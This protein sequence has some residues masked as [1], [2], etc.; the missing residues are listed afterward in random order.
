M[1][2]PFF[3]KSH[4][5]WFVEINRKQIN[6]GK[7]RDEAFRQY[8]SMMAGEAPVTGRSTVI[9]LLDQFLI[10]IKENRA[11]RTFDWYY[12]H[13]NPFSKYVGRRTVGELKPIHVTRWLATLPGGTTWKNGAARAVCRAFNWA[14]KQG[15]IRYSPV[16]GLEKPA[17]EHRECYITEDQW[18]AALKILPADDS[19]RDILCFLRET[20]ARPIEARIVTAKHWDR[21][22][23]RIVFETKNSKGKR[24]RRVIRLNQA[25]QEI[26][27]RLAIKTPEG[28]LFRNRRGDPWTMSALNQCCIKLKLDFEFFPY[29][30]RHSWI[31]DALLRGVDPMTVSI[32]AGHRDA[33]MVMKV[34]GHLAQQDSFL[35]EK[36]KQATGED[37]A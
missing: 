20:G 25:A 14:K 16:E 2:K 11:P 7:D 30:L 33:S 12:G 35:E 21:A 13:L 37:V 31:T 36:L 17:A 3:K 1:R 26:V 15:L 23:K 18:A 32:L 5:A 4:G 6:L 29:V 9:S 8:H 34:Y 28:P 19:A 24:Y 27:G 10:W 22:N